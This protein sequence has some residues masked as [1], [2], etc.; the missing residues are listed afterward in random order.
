MKHVIISIFQGLFKYISLIHVAKLIK[1]LL[2][3]DPQ[4]TD[5]HPTLWIKKK[6]KTFML[7]KGDGKQQPPPPLSW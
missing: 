5:P 2:T 7:K 6:Q 4:Y 3:T 1:K